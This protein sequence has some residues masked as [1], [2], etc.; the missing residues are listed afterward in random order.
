MAD[1]WYYAQRG[2]QLGPVSLDDLKAM[3][4]DRRVAF[5][6]LVWR[7]G[8]PNWIE[9]RATPELAPPAPVL[10]PAPAISFQPINPQAGSAPV[11]QMQYLTPRDTFS[12]YAGF[13]LRFVA[14]LLDWFVLMIPLVIFSFLFHRVSAVPAFHVRNPTW[15][16]VGGGDFFL[17]VAVWWLYFALMES[18]PYQATLGKLALGLIVTDTQGRPLT[19]GR[20][21]GRAFA[22]LINPYTL[23]IGYMMAGFTERKQG[24]HDLIAGTLVIRK[25]LPR[26]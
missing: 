20:A 12:V 14:Y 26:G 18:S 25:E 5:S 23:G 9:A 21:T 16:F 10:P 11:Q 15:M 4:Q 17:Q 3:L 19:F 22:K 7:E 6:D 8:M 24:L 13:W 1:D 2:K